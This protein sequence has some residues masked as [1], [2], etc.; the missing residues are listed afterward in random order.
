MSNNY[1]FIISSPHAP[2]LLL[3]N[4]TP[5]SLLFTHPPPP[6]STM[7]L[8]LFSYLPFDRP[9]QYLILTFLPLLLVRMHDF[10]SSFLLAGIDHHF[11]IPSSCLLVA[12]FASLFVI[13]LFFSSLRR[14][15]YIPITSFFLRF[16]WFV[17]AFLLIFSSVSSALFPILIALCA[18]QSVTF[19]LLFSRPRVFSS[20]SK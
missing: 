12:L 4:R 17:L 15:R 16:W 10:S 11:D 3:H 9:Y 2:K 14:L 8:R 19:C 20:A 7:K 6:P 1:L 13:A 5:F 18:E